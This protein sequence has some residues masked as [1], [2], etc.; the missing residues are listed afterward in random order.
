MNVL[1]D[2]AFRGTYV[3]F[4]LNVFVLLVST[5]VMLTKADNNNWSV[6]MLQ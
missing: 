3:Y 1:T 2:F 4:F 5:E 6:T